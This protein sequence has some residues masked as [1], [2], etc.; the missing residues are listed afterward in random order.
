MYILPIFKIVAQLSHRA[1]RGGRARSR[2]YADIQTEFT[3]LF[4][5]CVYGFEVDRVFITSE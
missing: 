2:R 5:F 3:F 1:K 4:V